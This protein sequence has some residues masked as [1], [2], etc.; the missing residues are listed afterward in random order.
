MTKRG[1]G[2]GIIAAGANLY[3][4]TNDTNLVAFKADDSTILAYKLLSVKPGY[5]VWPKNSAEK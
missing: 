2:G 4:L 5:S 3:A 1:A